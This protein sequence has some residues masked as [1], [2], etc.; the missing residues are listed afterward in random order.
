MIFIFTKNRFNEYYNITQSQSFSICKESR[1][2]FSLVARCYVV[3]SLATRFK[4]RSLLVA[5]V[6]RCKK[7]LITRCKIRSLLVA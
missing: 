3:K 7:S 6:A 1:C 5:E 2:N 4:I